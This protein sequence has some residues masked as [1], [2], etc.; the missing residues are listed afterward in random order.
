MKDYHLFVQ[1]DEGRG[2]ILINQYMNQNASRFTNDINI[3]G[4]TTSFVPRVSSV[5]DP[6]PISDVQQNIRP[7]QSIRINKFVNQSSKSLSQLKIDAWEQGEQSNMKL[8]K[9]SSSTREKLN[10]L[11]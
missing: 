7:F 2:S 8:K 1:V 5:I 4:N 6:L 3:F 11:K 10:F 9:E